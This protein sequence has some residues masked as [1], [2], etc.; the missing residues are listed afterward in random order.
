MLR[1]AS[2]FATILSLLLSCELPTSRAQT[3]ES[4]TTPSATTTGANEP[5]L[6]L[7]AN[8]AYVGPDSRSMRIGRRGI[9]GWRDETTTLSWYGYLGTAG[10]LSASVEIERKNDETAEYKLQI[11]P[12]DG[13]APLAESS[14]Q[15]P[16]NQPLDFGTFKVVAAGYHEFRLSASNRSGDSFGSPRSLV[17]SGPPLESARFNREPRRNTASVH[18]WYPVERSVK[19]QAFYN[20]ITAHTEPLWSYYMAC[21]FHRGYFGMQ[22]NSPTE[23]R[24]I[25]SV[26]D[27]G[28]EAVDR[29]KVKDED[30]VQLLSKGDNVVANGFG[31]EGTGGHSHLVYD[32]KRDTTYRYLVVAHPEND[33]TVFAGYFYFPDRQQWDLIARF[34]APKDGGFLHS[35]YSFDENFAGDNGH[36]LRSASFG[37]QWIYT[38]DGKWMELTKCYFTCD[39]TG[40]KHR[41]DYDAAVGNE[42][43][44]LNT[45]GFHQG[46]ITFR[47]ELERRRQNRPPTDI[48]L[49]LLQPK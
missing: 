10:T 32:W 35:L 7:P 1:R 13:Q 37:N 14:L 38:S 22:V 23:R 44:R 6:E 40:R 48:P 11:S 9:R 45:G 15:A 20:E 36:L 18:L 28:N 19:V 26:W 27:S 47:Q 34:K 3:T 16:A 21:G 33:T 24:I 25:F 41:Q 49:D 42:R 4:S 31:N 43:F 39:E 30:L 29:A 8:T 17:L 2:A 5:R 46:H 12:V